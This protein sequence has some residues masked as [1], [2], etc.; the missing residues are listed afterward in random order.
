MHFFFGFHT[1]PTC[2]F[3]SFSPNIIHFIL[4]LCTI[5][6]SSVPQ[7]DFFASHWP[8]DSSIE[9]FFSQRVAWM[10]LVTQSRVASRCSISLR[11]KI[12]SAATTNREDCHC[13]SQT[14]SPAVPAPVLTVSDPPLGAHASASFSRCSVIPP[15][16]FSYL[17]FKWFGR[18]GFRCDSYSSSWNRN[19]LLHYARY[20]ALHSSFDCIWFPDETC[21]SCGE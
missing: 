21:S 19:W 6:S 15:Q 13:F 5:M 4:A 8:N 7:P 16:K 1:I 11:L 9:V 20:F 18:Q 12:R 14:A 2:I 10:G 17:D 3:L